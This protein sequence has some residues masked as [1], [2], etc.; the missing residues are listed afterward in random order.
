VATAGKPSAQTAAP[1]TRN[2]SRMRGM[3]DYREVPP[4]ESS[5]RDLRN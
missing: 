5:R 2:R 4:I 1:A 3:A